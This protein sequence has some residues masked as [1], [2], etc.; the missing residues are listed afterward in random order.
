MN[1][2]EPIWILQS[3]RKDAAFA[4]NQVGQLIVKAY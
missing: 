2:T 1:E 3:I 4:F